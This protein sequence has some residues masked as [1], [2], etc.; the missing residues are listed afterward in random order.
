LIKNNK[1]VSNRK[2]NSSKSISNWWE[3]NYEW[4]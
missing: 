2:S 1:I 4:V 3:Q